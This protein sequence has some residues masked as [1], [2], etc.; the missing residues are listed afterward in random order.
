MSSITDMPPVPAIM[1]TASS[2]MTETGPLLVMAAAPARPGHV[3]EREEL[4]AALNAGT[5]EALRLF[6]ERH[7]DSRYR[8]QARDALRV[9]EQPPHQR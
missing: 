2:G 5:L 9:F 8:Q 7:P 1:E 3:A 4:D 6:L